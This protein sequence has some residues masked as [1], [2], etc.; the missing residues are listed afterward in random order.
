MSQQSTPRVPRA[1]LIALAVVGA[2]V[3][4]VLGAVGLTMLRSD[5]P[6][7][8]RPITE[9]TPDVPDP[10]DAVDDLLDAA[11]DDDC[12]AAKDVASPLLVDAGVCTS[13]PWRLV[14]RQEATPYVGSAVLR[15]G[16]ATVEAA[17]VVDVPDSPRE[18]TSHLTFRLYLDEGEWLIGSYR[19]GVLAAAPPAAVL[20][21]FF[22]AVFDGQ[23]DLATT[24]ATEA[25][26]DAQG[27]CMATA[28][29]PED[30]A[31]V[32]YEFGE[33]RITG[34]GR[35]RRAVVPVTL[36]NGDDVS[37]GDWELAVRQGEWRVDR[38]P[39]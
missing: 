12:G 28:F 17:L 30:L 22:R 16:Q 31:K 10:A 34:E 26:L 38:L 14:A 36:T 7:P 15:G 32:T 29:D 5:E 21:S 33:P 20:D 25:Y 9:V 13:R 6:G 19:D 37:A 39:G 3:V 24:Y 23:C 35:E 2:L 8:D 18:R 11:A 4:V 1:V 27:E